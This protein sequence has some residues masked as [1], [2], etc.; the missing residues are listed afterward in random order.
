M[1][2]WIVLTS[3]LLTSGAFAAEKKKPE[4]TPT[5]AVQPAPA[6]PAPVID[7]LVFSGDKPEE[8]GRLTWHGGSFKFT[9]KADRSAR[10]FFDKYLKE[11]VD[12]YLK[13]RGCPGQ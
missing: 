3:L 7:T 11:I 2:R 4:P 13:E 1:K 8:I 12:A 5:P 10:L 9:G 6:K